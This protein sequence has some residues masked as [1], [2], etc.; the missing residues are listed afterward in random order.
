MEDRGSHV[1]QSAV[2]HRCRV[3]VGDIDEGYGVQRV[4]GVGCAVGVDGIVGIAV[5]G[6]DDR[7]V[8]VGL[9][10]LYHLLDALVDS[11]YG[12]GDGTLY[13]YCLNTSAR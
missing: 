10:S 11:P 7:L 9:G 8:V 13:P 4:G 12:L 3:V 6:D 1:G 2:F 5:V